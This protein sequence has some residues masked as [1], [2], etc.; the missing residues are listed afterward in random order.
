LAK[1]IV[2]ARGWT[3]ANP[4]VPTFS[5][6]PVGSPFFQHVE[7]AVQHQIISGY[8]DGTFKPGN[9]ATRGQISKILYNA[10]NGA[11]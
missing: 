7:T 3:L 5:D 11:R 8:A 4:S 9:N 6:V 2:L 10:L 1:I